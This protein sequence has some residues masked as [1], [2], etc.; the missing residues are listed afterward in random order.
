MNGVICGVALAVLI[1]VLQAEIIG[2]NSGPK[3]G[4]TYVVLV[5]AVQTPTCMY[6]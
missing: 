4:V 3:A 2:F 1:G 6:A 5:V